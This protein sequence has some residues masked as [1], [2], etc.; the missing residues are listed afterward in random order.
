MEH[1]T[2]TPE[3]AK[4][5]PATKGKTQVGRPGPAANELMPIAA[6]VLPLHEI[7]R[8]LEN[9]AQAAH[10][11]VDVSDGSDIY[12]SRIDRL[13]TL[14]FMTSRQ[15][16]E[17]GGRNSSESIEFLYDAQALILGA[18]AVDVNSPNRDAL[19]KLMLKTID[20]VINTDRWEGLDDAELA[21][22]LAGLPNPDQVPLIRPQPKQES[23]PAEP[24][25]VTLATSL[26]ASGEAG[27]SLLL[28]ASFDI[29]TLG[30]NLVKQVVDLGLDPEESCMLRTMAVRICELNSPIMSYLSED[31]MVSLGEVRVR[32]NRGALG[33]PEGVVVA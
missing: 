15:A 23:K 20:D 8:K 13:L 32:L 11:V 24:Q 1:S 33:L 4:K 5:A 14:H 6:W 17:Q 9:L 31:D 3:K 16:L 27:R 25:K 28:Q 19:H 18:Q 2:A 7:L 30:M 10:E 29:E 21:L 22:I 26:L 12:G